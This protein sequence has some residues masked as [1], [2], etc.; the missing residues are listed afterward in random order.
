MR[1]GT[2][3]FGWNCH[4]HGLARPL[5]SSAVWRCLLIV[6]IAVQMV[7][8]A[9]RLGA[10]ETFVKDLAGAGNV[11]V[12]GTAVNPAD[13]S[14]YIVGSFQGGPLTI[15]GRVL[16]LDGGVGSSTAFIAK[17]SSDG[18]WL[19]AGTLFDATGGNTLTVRGVKVT[20]SNVYIVGDSKNA[21]NVRIQNGLDVFT[22][23]NGPLQRQNLAIAPFVTRL[24]SQGR[25]T[26]TAQ[27]HNFEASPAYGYAIAV[28]GAGNTFICG[29][30]RS[31]SLE[32][33]VSLQTATGLNFATNHAFHA[34]DPSGKGS[35][36]WNGEHGGANNHG[37]DWINTT[38]DGYVAK[39]DKDG[40]WKWVATGGG[41]EEDEGGFFGIA[42][43]DQSE[44]YVTANLKS[45]GDS[46][47]AVF[48][49]GMTRA[50]WMA[51]FTKFNDFWGSIAHPADSSNISGWVGKLYGIGAKEGVWLSSENKDVADRYLPVGSRARSVVWT[52]GIAYAA[53][54]HQTSNDVYVV[55]MPGDLSRIDA[56]TGIVGTTGINDIAIGSSL[57]AD[58][59][60]NL[61]LTGVFGA[62][63]AEFGSNTNLFVTQGQGVFVA[64]L[65]SQLQWQWA[66]ATTQLPG[67]VPEWS[68]VTG[69]VDPQTGRFTFSG[70]F[71]NGVLSLG[72]PA[73]ATILPRD[74][75][76][77][78]SRRGFV[79]A[80]LTTGDLLE[81]VE[82]TV[83]S[84]FGADQVIPPRTPQTVFRGTSVSVSVPPVIY[85]D[86]NGVSVSAEDSAAKAVVRHTCLGY[87]VVGTA[88]AGDTASYNFVISGD[89]LVRFLW[90]TEYALDVRNNLDNTD[91]ELTSTAAGSP[92]PVVQ[93]HWIEEGTISTAF[94]DGFVP[95]PFAN[96]YGTRYRSTGYYASGSVMGVLN[97]AP[98]F[99]GVNQHVDLGAMPAISF[100][101][102]LT[103]EAWVKPDRLAFYGGI[104]EFASADKSNAIYLSNNETTRA[105]NFRVYNGSNPLINVIVPDFFTVGSWVHVAATVDKAGVTTIYANG[106]PVFTKPNTAGAPSLL[107]PA[108]IRDKSFIGYGFASE[109]AYFP[110]QIGEVRLWN[111]ARS[112]EQIRAGQFAQ[113]APTETG[114]AGYW[115]LTDF[116]ADT[117]S[118]TPNAGSTALDGTVRNAG[119]E[120]LVPGNLREFI[121]WASVQQRQQIPQF[122][123]SGPGVIEYRWVKE[124]R[125]QVS[126][127]PAALSEMVTIT[128]GGATV[129]GSGEYWFTNNAAVRITA[130]TKARAGEESYE[131]KGYIGGLGAVTPVND[132]GTLS[133]TNRFYHIAKLDVG[134]SITWDYSDRIY[135][136]SVFIGDPIN[137]AANGTF[138]GAEAIPDTDLIDSGNMPIATTIVS[139]SPPGSTIEDMKI[140]DDVDD[141][142]Y[143]LR[144]GIV[145]LEWGRKSGASTT[146]SVFT[147]VT[148]SFRTNSPNYTHVANTPP[149]PLDS[150]KTNAVAFA[151]LKYSASDKAVVS[152]TAEFSLDADS[153]PDPCWSVLLFTE[154][155]DGSPAK[156]DVSRERLRVRTVLTKRWDKDLILTNAVVGGAITS[157]LHES[158]V[159]H[160]GYLYFDKTRY[161][162]LV[163]DRETRLGPIIPVNLH[164]QAPLNETLV[165]VWY[166]TQE[167][168]HWPFQSVQYTPKWPTNPT[169]IVIAS[170][171]GSEGYDASGVLQP[172][173][174]TDRY[175]QVSI[176]QQPDKTLPGYNPNEEHALIAP[177]RLRSTL[178]TPPPTAFAL[179][180]NL[181]VT[182]LSAEYTSDPY[183]LV[184]YFDTGSTNWGMA[185]YQVQT[186]DP[187]LPARR[188]D[189]AEGNAVGATIA[190]GAEGVIEFNY[191]NYKSVTGL[192]VDEAVDLELSDTLLGINGGRYYL[193]ASTDSQFKLSQTPGGEPVKTTVNLSQVKPS[194]LVRRAFPHVFEY[195]MFA[196][197]QV[198]A[199]YPLQDVIGATPCP[200]TTGEDLNPN[201]RTYWEDHKKQPWAISGSKDPTAGIRSRFY[202]PLQPQ[203]WSATAAP[204]DCIPFVSDA[205]PTW[206]TNHVSWPAV[207]PVLKAGES[208]TFS[209]GETRTDNPNAP[210]APGVI[211]WAAGRIVYDDA[212]PA[213]NQKLMVANYLARMA[214]PLTTYTVKLPIAEMPQDLLPTGGKVI[215]NGTQWFFKDLDASLQ[216]R[217]Y[218]DQLSQVLSLR[219]FVDGKT[220]GD[221]T[222]TASPGSISVL[223]PNIL[224]PRESNAVVNL[225]SPAPASWAQAVSNLVRL[226]RDPLKVST[227]PTGAPA[228]AVGLAPTGVAGEARPATQFGPGLALLPN[229]ELLNPTTLTKGG[230]VTLAENDDESLGAAPVTLHIVRIQSTPLYRGAIKTLNPPNP[231][232]E[233]LTLRHSG[234]FGANA[235]TLIFEWYYKSDDGAVVAPPVPPNDMGP[236]QLFADVSGRNGLGM[237]E[238]NLAGAGSVTLTDNRFFVRWRHKDAAEV[239]SQWAGAAN[240]RPPAT[241]EVA[242]DTYIPQLAEGWIKRVT[243][244]INPFDARITDFR[245]NSTP[246]TYA[247]MVQQAGA[248]Y[249]GPV[250]LNADKNVVE[251]TGLI[252]LYTTVVDRAKDLSINRGKP[253]N[254]PAVNNSILL[255]ASRIADLQ[256]LLGNEA[257]TDAQDSTIGFGTAS[258]EYGVLA[259]TIFTFQ[260]QMPTLLDEELALLRGRSEEG[261]YP[262]YNRLL[263]NFTRAEGEAAYALSYAISDV[264][265]DGFI[266]EADGR[267]LYPQ[268]HGDAWGHYLS[269]LRTYYDLLRHPNFDWQAR[270][271]NLQIEGVVVAVDYLDERK[272]AEAAAAK[273]K[274]GAEVVNLTYRARYVEDPDGQWQGYQD[275]DANRGWGVVD[276]AR[277]SG[278]AALFD[279]VTA[280]AI[281]PANDTTHTGIE[282]VDRTTVKELS[283]ISAQALEVRRQ[284]DNANK[285]LNPIGLSTD[286]MPFDIDPTFLEVGSVIQGLSHFDQVHDRALKAMQN[287]VD[288]FNNAN[289]LNNMLRQV[290]NTSAQFAQD[291]ADQDTDYRNRLIEI[292]GTPYEG[293]IGAG[294]TYPAGYNGP[295]IYQYMYVDTTGV[296]EETIPPPSDTFKAFFEPMDAG[297]IKSPDG[298]SYTITESFKN[299]YRTDVDLEGSATTDYS[300]TLEVDMPMTAAGYSFQAPAEWGQRRSPG[301]IQQTLSELVQSEADFKLALADYAAHMG[302]ITELMD[303]MKAHSDL[304][305]ERISIAEKA[306]NRVIALNTALSVAEGVG[307]AAE[308]GAESAEKW[309][310]WGLEGLPKMVGLAYD[311]FSAVRA[312][313]RGSSLGI[314]TAFSGIAMAAEKSESFL[315]GSKQ[316]VELQRD[317]SIQKA[318]F[319]YGIQE[320]LRELTGMLGE[321]PPKR[322]EA[323][324]RQE[325]LRQASDKY[326]SVLESGLR[327][328]EE[329]E[330][331]NKRT[332]GAVQQ[333]R[334]QDFTFRVAR[335]SALSKYRAAFD[336]AARYV[337]L[338]AKAYD[339][340]TNLDPIDPASA[341]PLLT[342]VIRARTLGAMENGVPR[343]GSG[344]LADALATLKVNFDVLRSQMG[345]N[346]PQGESG[347]FSLRHEL[348]R[349]RDSDGTAWRQQ[350]EKLRVPDL[351]QVAEFRRYCRPFAPQSAGAQPGL[352]I[353]FST[354]ITF[355]NNLFGWPL[356][357]G[358]S[359]YDPTLFATKVRSVGV[360]FDNYAG[361]GLGTTPR[362]YLVPAGLDIMYVPNSTEFATREWNVVDQRIP[363]PLPLNQSALRN[364]QWIPTRDS[365]NGTLA[366]IRRYSSFRAFHNAG[367][368]V[369]EMTR[370]SRLVGRSV[371]NTRWMLIIPGG[372][373]LSDQT[374]GLDTFIHGLR[375]TDGTATDSRGNKRDGNGITDIKLSFETYAISGN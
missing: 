225:V 154:Q 315:E 48:N 269:A 221:P 364:P 265:K 24:D 337:Y 15:G 141:K 286:V 128:G 103:V 309:A 8:I 85:E 87:E 252:E 318:E 1:T 77:P 14:T 68:G 336:L 285:G 53:Y 55:Q 3:T 80:V 253:V 200:A 328:M 283:L 226:S 150:D 273:A 95:S 165:V 301:E 295:D 138:V 262:A 43:N 263:W 21:V 44:V 344:G 23:S 236:W 372:T 183:V 193:V 246:A 232:D 358:D 333:N 38:R 6:L 92:D 59:L 93:K 316:I 241:N 347:Q 84:A 227:A 149:V 190:A 88:L 284:L 61:Y 144:P 256:L 126:V 233:K 239:W 104:V 293:T 148:V 145:L 274:A 242:K 339:Y 289:Q 259:P 310:G 303:L 218:Y 281:L 176:Y 261:A 185:V 215:V 157:S 79:G 71:I 343:L 279:W 371:W 46:Q 199:P 69:A 7:G 99:N 10:A 2:F 34:R 250:A 219:G 327:L 70:S 334:Y 292:F 208:L 175:E 342:Q 5:H 317:I 332:A 370:D 338:T 234:D 355:G 235:E 324:R 100:D 345:F 135:L 161:N 323:L 63:G 311:A 160:N 287:A 40:K 352:V 12:V 220:L 98:K 280:N 374:E 212:N 20:P 171:M 52:G 83:V 116:S 375:L 76:T 360:W 58:S 134:S 255:A 202:Y 130:P 350:L 313:I 54:Y 314:E 196:G 298:V 180:N 56:T 247:S 194:A 198:L 320:Q 82:L 244:A 151:A 210:G 147:Q 346:N 299:F 277:R 105:L 294:K 211:G 127:A 366:E 240:S 302:A 172:S 213:M 229:A 113:L 37:A 254:A 51:E 204:G 192:K 108:A 29:S 243:G 114:L 136:G 203:F 340:E 67:S 109:L 163:H 169:R 117:P 304:G 75:S 36:K 353:P 39:L 182:T 257:Y 152:D 264:N 143:P 86:E 357:P 356:G 118:L 153:L 206:V 159:P 174:D 189:F 133:G 73:N 173:F 306:R 195:S 188:L 300:E 111:V 179:R 162:A 101:E 30:F 245:N 42:V 41:V 17:M 367:F 322:I 65:D 216:P 139:G 156:G 209:G 96:G 325:A 248:P 258:S 349:M 131:L 107:P 282:K 125:L 312:T 296:S 4:G 64:K 214:S 90:K 268:G 170:Q 28:D 291:A 120:I 178:A 191:P 308:A 278:C 72:T 359:A 307:A 106:V 184:Q 228:Y 297:F 110:G 158:S 230:Y 181:N 19:W 272:F 66:K 74:A 132:K 223:Q 205:F 249:R 290:A 121:P 167:G 112:V 26:W 35:V 45:D 164:P 186:V 155:P 331:H 49:R 329:R 50:I 237:S 18:S 341:G 62:P 363:V 365:L 94:I 168:I 326:R 267:V 361:D 89:T 373:F 78:T 142:L 238:I 13:G 260:N 275:T 348:F 47:P 31:D 197:Q 81:Q 27:A 16:E 115:K 57:V 187:N 335:N 305:Q 166:R 91:K 124:N 362:V 369:D 271:E 97:K 25:H 217:V 319:K 137:F 201:Q 354:Q 122:R 251:N 123:M 146:R 330:L 207:V 9:G 102:G 22:G 60:N 140:W 119:A 222:L 33:F 177:S 224:T 288:L 276:S 270:S 351:W 321:E 231:F 129:T 32:D 11:S 368:S 266:N